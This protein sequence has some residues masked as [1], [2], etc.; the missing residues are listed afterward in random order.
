MPTVGAD[1]AFALGAV[2]GLACAEVSAAVASS[3]ARVGLAGFASRP[4]AGLSGGQKQRVAIAGALAAAPALLLLDELT[5]FLDPSDQRRVLRAVRALV[6]GAAPAGGAGGSGGGGG[7][8]GGSGSDVGLGL[9]GAR[10]GGGGGG[11]AAPAPAAAPVTAV[12]VTHRLEEL[13]AAD[14]VSILEGGRVV[15]TGPP[16]AARAALRRLGAP[17]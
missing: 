10:A 2:P 14:A 16:A 3:L 11:P 13:G 4:A 12:W 17:A 7:G 15:F 6:D 8:G 1:V 9:E 5:T